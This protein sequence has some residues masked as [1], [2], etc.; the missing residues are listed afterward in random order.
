MAEEYRKAFENYEISNFGNIR[1]LLKDGTYKPLNCS[2]NNRGYKYIQT[3]RKN[4][5]R[6]YLI[7]H[8]VMY[9][10]KGARKDNLVIDHI[11]RNKLNNCIDNLRYVTHRQNL[12]N[13]D[14]Y[15]VHITEQDP[16]K[17]KQIYKKEYGE[18]NKDMIRKKKRNYYRKNRKSFLQRKR[19]IC[20]AEYMHCHRLR[21]FRSRK[22]QQCQSYID[23]CEKF[24][25]AMF[26][27]IE[28]H[29]KIKKS[30]SPP[31]N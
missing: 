8:L 21:H 1:R 31:K 10:F 11:D 29:K 4:S 25:R 28:I 5:R 14:K 9:A 3:K 15:L 30:L 13:T 16:K 20:G 2:V 7:H 23:Y 18:K 24:D 12:Q 6:N 26:D 27:A 19:C 22:H 17:R